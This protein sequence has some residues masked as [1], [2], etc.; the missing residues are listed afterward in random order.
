MSEI[1]RFRLHRVED[2]SGVSGTGVVAEG[3]VFSDGW[4]VLHWLDREPM[5][6][7][8]IVTWLNKGH[9]GV[10]KV[11]GHNGSTRVEWIDI[12]NPIPG[13]DYASAWT[14]LRGYV[15]EADA[16]G[17]TIDPAS[18]LRYLDEL[19]RRALAP[20]RDWIAKLVQQSG[21]ASA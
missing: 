13:A 17:G 18:M 20:G 4:T 16:S 15:A 6:E 5:N 1:R 8:S 7:P 11:H 9:E 3:V 14:E 19:K 21:E 12:V 10:V 2:V